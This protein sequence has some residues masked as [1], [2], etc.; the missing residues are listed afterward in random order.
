LYLG[1]ARFN[2]GVEEEYCESRERGKVRVG[3]LKVSWGETYLLDETVQPLL[4]NTA[5][6]YK[7]G[8]SIF[9]VE[10]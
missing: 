7:D 5:E 9:F 6:G 3:Q 10:E 2:E 8:F 1:F 4:L